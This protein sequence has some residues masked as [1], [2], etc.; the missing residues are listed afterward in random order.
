MRSRSIRHW[1]D[2]GASRHTC[3]AAQSNTPTMCATRCLT[4][5]VFLLNPS[6]PA[7]WPPCALPPLPPCP[8][9]PIPTCVCLPCVI[10]AACHP[11]CSILADLPPGTLPP[12]QHRNKLRKMG[13]R[14]SSSNW[15]NDRL[16]WKEDIAYKKEL[17][18]L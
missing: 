1:R 5:A 7:D 2:K 17:G 12:Q 14:T 13:E 3:Q 4:Q 18:F 9:H 10:H 16:T 6:P 15:T 8:L 11:R